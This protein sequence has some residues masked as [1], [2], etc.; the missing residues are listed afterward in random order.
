MEIRNYCIKWN[1]YRKLKTLKNHISDK[2]LVLSIT[3]DK[4]GSNEEESIEVLNVFNLI[5]MKE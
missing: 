5:D 2:L 1:K 4:C 3:F